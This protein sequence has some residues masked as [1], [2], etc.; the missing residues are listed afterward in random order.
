MPHEPLLLQS[1]R[2][3]FVFRCADGVMIDGHHRG[4]SRW[5]YKS[6]AYRD[7]LGGGDMPCD[8]TWLSAF[9]SNPL[10]VGQMVNNHTREVPSN[11]EYVEV[12]VPHHYLLPLH[13]RLLPN[14]HY[15]PHP[16]DN[17][18]AGIRC[19]ALVSTTDIDAGTELCSSYLTVVHNTRHL[20]PG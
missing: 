15:S 1:L 4:L 17:G 6:C 11:V 7:V 19:V 10:A 12:T 20:T 18:A 13:W 9:P 2:N 3:P 5:I 14:I 16:Q 8:A